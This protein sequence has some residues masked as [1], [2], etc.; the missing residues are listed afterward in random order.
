MRLKIIV[1]A[2][3]MFLTG[4]ESM[5][6]KTQAQLE[7]E[8]VTKQI[9][10][11]FEKVNACVVEVNK[12]PYVKKMYEEILA[13]NEKSPNKY[14]LMLSNEKPTAEQ[15]N[16]L[17]NALPVATKCREID[18]LNGLPHKIVDLKRSNALDML[19][20][21]LIRG[22]VTIGG[23]NVEKSKIEADSATNWEQA[24]NEMNA[25]YIEAYNAEMTGRRQ[26]AV[27]MM[28]YIMQ[29]Q[30]NTLMQQQLMYQQQIQNIYNNRQITNPTTTTNCSAFGNQINCTTR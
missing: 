11:N 22:E 13:Q 14:Q 10:D 1:I 25:R 6:Q 5:Q 3:A 9:K 19:Y 26:A 30:Q 15:I 29:Q 8:R 21:K 28:P 27:A 18:G 2:V 4:C 16:I 17:I 12:D 23:A 7:Y 20:L 24:S